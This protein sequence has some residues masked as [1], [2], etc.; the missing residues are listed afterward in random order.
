MRYL[1]LVLACLALVIAASVAGPL[2]AAHAEI[3]Q[4]HGAD[5][6]GD[7]SSGAASQ[8]IV[9]A[10]AQY[11]TNGSMTVTATMNGDI[12][13]GPRTFFSFDVRSY[14]PPAQCTGSYVSMFGFSDDQYDTVMVEG[15]SGTGSSSVS[16]N[17]NTIAFG[18]SGNALRDR[19]YSC[20]TLTV[21]QDGGGI[22][23]QLNVPVFFDGYGPDTDSDGLKDNQ[24]A[25]PTV[26]GPGTVNGCPAP[27][28]AAA[29]NAPSTAPPTP[30]ASVIT[31]HH[32][33]VASA[34]KKL[35]GSKRTICIKRHAALAKCKKIKGAKKRAACTRKAK[36]I[37]TRKKSRRHS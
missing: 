15:V 30:T 22:V 12:A 19:D 11:D 9:G 16:R 18:A 26:P 29:P 21:S 37:G 14:A 1:K 10:T 13:S 3:R 28:A 8:D 2:S 32:T 35:R 7:S 23:D 4:G 36:A 27:P 6:V 34:C 25:C 17:G 5:P 31:K 24:D 20:M 33:A